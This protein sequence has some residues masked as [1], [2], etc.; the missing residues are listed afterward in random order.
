MSLA[1][2]VTARHAVWTNA[3][4]GVRCER[5]TQQGAFEARRN[6]VLGGGSIAIYTD[7]TERKKAELSNVSSMKHAECVMPR[8][9]ATH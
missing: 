4:K 5:R 8:A 7:I 9:H 6:P 2:E 1:F 3:F